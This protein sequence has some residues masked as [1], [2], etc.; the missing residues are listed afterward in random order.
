ML[1]CTE[2]Q[3]V[4]VEFEQLRGGVLQKYASRG[5][6]D[7]EPEVVCQKTRAMMTRDGEMTGYICIYVYMRSDSAKQGTV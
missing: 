1:R 7:D 4:V 5:G 3:R 6:S 2:V